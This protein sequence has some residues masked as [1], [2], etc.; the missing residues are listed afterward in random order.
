MKTALITGITGQDGSYLTEFLLNKGY[1]VYGLVR[2]A[3]TF[4][5][6]RIDGVIESYPPER[7]DF[8][9]ADMND[10][11]SLISVLKETEPD[12]IYHLAAQSHVKVS[13]EVPVYTFD[14]DATGTL[15]LFEAVRAMKLGSRIYFAGSSEMF[16][17]SPP[18]QDENTPFCPTSPYAA[19]KVV[20]FH[21][22][23]IYRDAYGMWIAGGM[24]FNHESPRRG[25]TFVT[26]KITIALSRIKFGV[27][28]TVYL[29]NLDAKRDWGYAPDFVEAM[30]TILQRDKPDDYVI[31]TGESHTVREFADA[32]FRYAGYDLEWT[33]KGLDEKGIDKATGCPLIAVHPRYFR[34][35]ETESLLGNATKARQ[36]LGWKPKTTFK[37]LVR[38]MV[39]ADLE[40]ERAII[41]GTKYHRGNR[42]VR[43]T[44]GE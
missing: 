37:K 29:G 40:R 28:D 7:F 43:K 11:N 14:T 38:L 39:D 30:W 34:P 35:L 31:A 23:R 15:R 3:S 32:A 10:I 22:S 13:F 16:G 5:T 36:K 12:E 44:E 41:E 21:L 6:V 1:R 4:N 9:R 8:Y 33:G 42:Y 27:Q 26:R 25:E 17:A 24:L 20:A 2:R 18:P 19:A